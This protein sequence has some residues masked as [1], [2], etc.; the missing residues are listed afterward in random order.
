MNGY[1]AGEFAGALPGKKFYAIDKDVLI[2]IVDDEIKI[3]VQKT[4]RFG[5][6]TAVKL[7]GSNCHVM[8]KFSLERIIENK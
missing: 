7:K 6:Y 1:Q 3:L 2:D 8:N 4:N 5:E